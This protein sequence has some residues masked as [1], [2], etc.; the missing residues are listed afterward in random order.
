MHRIDH[1]SAAPGNQFTEGS[2]TG[3][4]A[5]TIV[6]AAILNDI[7]ENICAVVEA[8]GFALTKGRAADLLDA[9]SALAS[10]SANQVLAATGRKRLAGGLQL[11]WC[12]VAHGAATDSL[13]INATFLTAFPSGNPPFYVGAISDAGVTTCDLN[14]MSAAQVSV[15]VAHRDSGGA[16]VAGTLF[17][18]ALGE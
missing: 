3:G 4:V 14:G 16:V 5:A 11:R 9:I 15:T 8:A 12:Q 1:P 13:G 7:Q 10:D 18:F 6:T 2:P 17:V